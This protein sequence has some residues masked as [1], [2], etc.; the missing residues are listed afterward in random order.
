MKKLNFNYLQSFGFVV[1]FLEADPTGN[2]L[3]YLSQNFS[4]VI[5][6]RN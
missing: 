5:L 4:S 3:K 2:M 6:L 1:L